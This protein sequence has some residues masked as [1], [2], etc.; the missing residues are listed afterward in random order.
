MKTQ[1]RFTLGDVERAARAAKATGAKAVEI[2]RDGT[3]RLV[4]GCRKE[5][6]PDQEP[7]REPDPPKFRNFKL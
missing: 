6:E 7:E 1:G 3:I 4:F 2:L 5:P